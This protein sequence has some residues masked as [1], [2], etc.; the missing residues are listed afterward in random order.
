MA[1]L[2]SVAVAGYY[3]TPAR[4]LPRIA[5]LLAPIAEKRV[6]FMDP[7]AGE[8]EAIFA[9]MG[10]LGASTSDVYLCEMEA[11]RHAAAKALASQSN[12]SAGQ[13]VLHG[14]AFH[15]TWER[16]HH[17]G[18]MG[19]SLLYLNPP[20]DLDP[21]YGRLEHKFLSRFTS[22]LTLGG[23]LMFVVPFT[24]L[25]ASAELLAREFV[26]VQ[27]FRFPSPEFEGFKQVILV[28]RRSEALAKADPDLQGQILSW[29]R[30]PNGIPELPEEGSPARY[31]LPEGEYYDVG[32]HDWV[33]RPVDI[34]TLITKAR[35]WMQTGRSG[36]KAP[37]SGVLPDLPVQEL[38]LRHY[39]VATPPRPAHIAAG[40][41]SGLFNGAQVDPD[42]ARTGLPSLLVKGV[43]DR[44]YRTVEEKTNKDGEVTGVV[45]VQQPKLVVTVLD[46][47]THCYHVLGSESATTGEVTVDTMTVADLLKHYGQSLMGVMERQ[48]PIFYDPRR[49]A[50]SIPLASSPRKLFTAQAH[51]TRAV[52]KLL[53]GVKATRAQRKGKAAIL[54]GEIGSGKTT[55]ALMAAKTMGVRRPLVMC[56]P[57][58][59]KS[60]TDEAAAV[61]PEASVRILQTVSDLEAVAADTSDQMVISI[62]SRE[63]AKLSHGWVGVGPACPK[64]G[65]TV[66]AGDLA[67]KRARCEHQTV[68]PVDDLARFCR[69]W[70]IRLAKHKP[71]SGT[72][73]AILTERMGQRFLEHYAAKYQDAGVKAPAFSGFEV[74]DLDSV[75]LAAMAVYEDRTEA[76]KTV[77]TR[78]L[79]AVG[80][81]EQIAWVACALMRVDRPYSYQSFGRDLLLLLKPGSELQTTLVEALS[82]AHTSY[83]SPWANFKQQLETVRAENGKAS[84]G[85]LEI[86]WSTGSLVVDADG[87]NEL[88]SALALLRS[89]AS[90]GKFKT[91]PEC[92]EPLFQAVPEPRRVSLAQHIKER[93][94]D[95]FDLLVLDEGHEYATD[96]SAQERSAHRLTALGIPTILQTGSVMNGYAKSLFVNMWCLSPNFR[97]EFARDES[98]VFVD[99]YGYRKRLVQEK[100]KDSGEI[101]EFGSN[102]DRVVRSEK[103]IGE[104]PG[105]LPLFLLRHL[106]PISVTLHKNDLAIDLPKCTQEKHL[107]AP[108]DEL[109][110]RYV[111]LQAEL[112][113]K[114]KKDR[115]TP[116]LAGKLFGQLAE[117]PSYLDRATKDTGNVDSGDFEIRYPESVGG[118]LVA[119]QAGFPTSVRSNKETWLIQQVTEE[120]AQ[121]RNVMVFSWHTNLLP[122]LSRLITEATGEAAPILW[123][124]KVA[125]G[126]RQDWITKEILKKKRRVLVVN[127]VAIQTGLN[128]LVHFSTEI[129]MENPACNPVIFRQAVGRVDRIGQKRPTRIL[130]PIYAGTLQ[131]QLYD[132]LMQK[133]AVSVSTDGLDPES[134]LQAAGVGEDNYLAGLS[135]GKQLW[136]MINE[137]SESVATRPT[138]KRKVA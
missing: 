1:R 29:S 49:D 69:T 90:L 45:Q 122:R 114:I 105:I 108:E 41:A 130:C 113:R 12:G 111:R 36:Q 132:L 75:I 84:V 103:I 124:D 72:L 121:G 96:G 85:S 102:S 16:G 73:K 93:Y 104:A 48:C 74:G 28:A 77:L 79:A 34:T 106:L 59:L 123:A 21:V 2:E 27:C 22:A 40:I 39:P 101:V 119:F 14:D 38:L 13:R 19:A 30:D 52:V 131:E 83:Y 60:W 64:C 99:R 125:T 82:K 23:V 8:G 37:V 4:L 76:A 51:A 117:L 3:P 42:D 100:D 68:T 110:K 43:F 138:K 15:V 109:L 66:P 10:A 94:A 35:P 91:S 116:D 135:I 24:A 18:R 58:L 61:L 120:L 44:E 89:A 112:V 88:L 129:W 5:G 80:T 6:A 92:G 97:E 67:K 46:M 26:G 71:S 54:L 50:T 127:P 56:P 134:A 86:S 31:S 118:D 7:C 11:T 107:I 70:A 137:E 57:H 78:A 81:Q 47:S 98:S 133:V 128:N 33:I 87:P 53:G 20:Y 115:F 63:A 136:A 17:G 95:L 62:L 25:A 126:K 9:I 32:F 65:A 55:V